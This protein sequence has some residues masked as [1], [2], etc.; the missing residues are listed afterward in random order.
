MAAERV[1]GLLLP[2]GD[3]WQEAWA[4]DSAL[5]LYGPD[6]FHPSPM[7]SYLAALVVAGQLTGRSPVGLPSAVT[8]RLGEFRIDPETAAVL[9]A[10]AAEAIE[11]QGV[12][13]RK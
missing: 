2:A 8:T 12:G 9:Q 10:A 1:G 5:Q 13:S 3:A 6:G 7:G 11:R 4:A